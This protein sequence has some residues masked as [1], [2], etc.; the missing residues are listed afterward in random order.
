M[1]FNAIIHKHRVDLIDF[2]SLQPEN[3]VDNLNNAFGVAE[4]EL[5]IPKLLDT[6]DMVFPD[7]RSIVVYISLYYSYFCLEHHKRAAVPPIREQLHMSEDESQVSRQKVKPVVTVPAAPVT[8]TEV[9][10]DYL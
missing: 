7:Q 4:K 10:Y 9:G 1:A 5:G 8:V 6:E 2:D 3:I